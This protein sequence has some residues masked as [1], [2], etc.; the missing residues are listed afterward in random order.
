MPARVDAVLAAV[1]ER[2]P[3]TQVLY[4]AA[5]TPD[6]HFLVQAPAGSKIFVHPMHR[7]FVESVR[8]GSPAGSAG[9]PAGSAESA[10][11]TLKAVQ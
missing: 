2:D 5:V 3:S 9:S 6:S 10:P 8:A 1:L 11:A 7:P 4:N